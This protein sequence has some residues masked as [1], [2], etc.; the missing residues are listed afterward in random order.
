MAYRTVTFSVKAVGEGLTYQ[1]Y[2]RYGDSSTATTITADTHL[3]YDDIVEYSGYNTPYH[4]SFQLTE[5]NKSYEEI[6][7]EIYRELRN[8]LFVGILF[9]NSHKNIIIQEKHNEKSSNKTTYMS[10]N[11]LLQFTFPFRVQQPC[12]R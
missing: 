11:C 10:F 7:Y 8:G 4:L 3:F 12:G 2:V 5:R 9:D 6:L 1:W